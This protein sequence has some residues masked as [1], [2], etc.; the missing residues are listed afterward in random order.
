MSHSLLNP[1][2][3]HFY[4]VSVYDNP[5][6]STNPLS[7]EHDDVTIPLAISG[8]NIFLDTRT[9]TQH[10]LNNCPHLHLTCKT[11]WNPQTVR[12]VSTQS[13]EAEAFD[14]GDDVLDPRLSQISSVHCF[15][16]MAENL[17]TLSVI[18]SDLPGHKTF[19]SKQ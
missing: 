9:P 6:D 3:L 13:V 18:Q 19:I 7:I 15:S 11:E 8:T 12:L 14:I 10:E 16:E 5:F 4:G 17:R 2:Q 1:N